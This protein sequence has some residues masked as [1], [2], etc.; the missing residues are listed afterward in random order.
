M[1]LAA[2][3]LS[4]FSLKNDM[5]KE[6]FCVGCASVVLAL[7]ALAWLHFFLV[8]RPRRGPGLEE[9]FQRL[10]VVTGTLVFGSIVGGILYKFTQVP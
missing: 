2:G 10:G 7:L 1:H 8:L 9:R 6:Q 5:T 4:L 3:R